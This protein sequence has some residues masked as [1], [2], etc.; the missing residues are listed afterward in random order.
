[1]KFAQFDS[2]EG[3][4]AVADKLN[5]FENVI[6]RLEEIYDIRPFEQ[7]SAQ[8][9]LELWLLVV[10]TRPRTVFELGCGMRA[11]TIALA[12]AAA[13]AP[14]CCV[15][16]VDRDPMDFPSF[17]TRHFPDLRFGPVLD[18]A[19]D[20][21]DFEIPDWWPRPIFMFYDAHDGGIPGKVI[22]QHAIARWFP[23]LAGQTVAIHDCC[24]ASPDFVLPP[25][26]YN[27]ATHWS[28]RRVA[29]FGEVQHL[30]EWMNR[31]R[32]DFWRPG[33]ELEKLGLGGNDSCL[34]ALTIPA[35]TELSLT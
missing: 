4:R 32:I 9:L 6:A 24:V 13:E 2:A 16:G 3:R 10:T 22:S 31:G 25:G 30:V 33:D 7:Q 35:E 21:T 27:E 1:M 26:S 20:A 34:I 18:A 23:K 5:L 29:G 15:R 28:G 14:A 17:A 19:I 8:S 11:S 12:L